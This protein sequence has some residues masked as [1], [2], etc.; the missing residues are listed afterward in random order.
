MKGKE[1]MMSI[2]DAIRII[3]I[4]TTFFSTVVKIIEIIQKAKEH[5]KSNRTPQ[6]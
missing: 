6:S 2:T 4:I 1:K 3:G 5:Q